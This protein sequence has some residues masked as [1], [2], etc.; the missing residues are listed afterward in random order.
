MKTQS[1]T[2]LVILLAISGFAALNWESIN[3][4]TELSVG[5]ATIN[6]PLG[7]ILLACIVLLT[8]LFLIFIM[9]MQASTIMMSRRQNK[10]MLAK[11]KLADEAEASR[12]TDL[13]Q[14]LDLEFKGHVTRNID[15]NNKVLNK[16][17]EVETLLKQP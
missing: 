17:E 7:L 11:Q 14:Y 4:T 3:T 9:S 10:A 16:L 1:F 8:V 2:L 15:L 12:F 5:F 6:F 13:K